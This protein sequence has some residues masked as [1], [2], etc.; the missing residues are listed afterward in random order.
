ME[1]TFIKPLTGLAIDGSSVKMV[2]VFKEKKGWRLIRCKDHSLPPETLE[3]SRK[4][5]NIIDPNRFIET[6]DVLS[7][8]MSGPVNRI[9]LSLPDEILKVTTHMFEGVHE[10]NAKIKQFI[11]WKEK[12]TLPFPVEKSQISI[13]SFAPKSKEGRLYLAAI[14]LKDI[15]SDYEMNFK[16]LKIN[17]EVIRPSG[18]NHINFYLD[19]LNLSGITGFLGLFEQYF[20]FFIFEDEQLIFYRG[21][22]KPLS[23]VY[24]LQE[25]DMTL[26]LFKREYP[27]SEI[28]KVYLGSQVELSQDLELEIAAYSEIDITLIDESEMISLDP[29]L[30]DDNE[31]KIKIG[32]YVSAIGAAQSLVA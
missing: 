32:P 3:L 30:Y 22:R 12:S 29:D 17:P 2:Q 31:E 24:F 25:I 10:S 15:I 9:G 13:H 20:T 19:H 7:Q 16:R 1:Y 18:I 6:V 23:Y 11:S 27:D 8:A 21:K 5:E 14:G 4:D 28:E 26:E